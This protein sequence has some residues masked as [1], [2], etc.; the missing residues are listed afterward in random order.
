LTAQTH[1]NLIYNGQMISMQSAP[2]LPNDDSKIYLLESSYINTGCWR[3]YV[4]TWELRNNKFFLNSISGKFKLRGNVPLFADWFTGTLTIPSGKLLKYIH[5]GFGGTYE[6]EE[7]ITIVKGRVVKIEY[8]DNRKTDVLSINI[9][10]LTNKLVTRAITD[11]DKVFIC[12]NEICAEQSLI[13]IQFNSDELFEKYIG[14]LALH[15]HSS[16]VPIG[17]NIAKANTMLISGLK[18]NT[19]TIALEDF[20]AKEISDFL[21]VEYLNSE[22]LPCL[23]DDS[24]LNFGVYKKQLLRPILSQPNLERTSCNISKVQDS[25]LPDSSFGD[26]INFDDV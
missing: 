22:G 15:L 24:W 1:E 21:G 26:D 20:W 4:G 23:K 11:A 7:L 25:M 8:K 3:G 18:V 19:I 10:Q 2:E 5:G 9:K 6:K 16:R 12:N 17:I 14:K 13:V